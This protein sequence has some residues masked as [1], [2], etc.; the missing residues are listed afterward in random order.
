[1]RSIGADVFAVPAFFEASSPEESFKISLCGSEGNSRA[2]ELGAK[3]SR[4]GLRAMFA[5]LQMIAR[6]Q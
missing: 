3:S 6:Y 1:M 2:G 4:I 5:T